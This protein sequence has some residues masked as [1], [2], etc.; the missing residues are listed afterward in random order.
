M[1][2]D[3][4][5][6]PRPKG[7]PGSSKD[8]STNLP[9]E[10][11]SEGARG[12]GKSADGGDATRAVIADRSAHEAATRAVPPRKPHIIRRKPPNPQARITTREVPARPPPEPTR[13]VPDPRAFDSAAGAPLVPRAAGAASVPLAATRAVSASHGTETDSDDGAD[14]DT[15]TANLT[16]VGPDTPTS[17]L[18]PTGGLIRNEIEAGAK[19]AHYELI[20]ELGRGGMAQVFLARDTKLGRLVAMKFIAAKSANLGKRFVAEARA[21]AACNHENIVTI[22]EVETFES[23]PYMVLEY[24]EGKP[25]SK[26]IRRRRVP[27]GRVVELIVP[28]VRAL[29]HAHELDLVHRDLKPDNVF[30]TRSGQVKVLDFGIAKA[31]SSPEA[32]PSGRASTVGVDDDA[33]SQQL[34]RYGTVVG[35]PSYM[36]PEQLNGEEIDHRTDLWAVGIIMFRMLAARHPLDS[37]KLPALQDS[38]EALDVP[39]PSI[40]EFVPAIP[41]AL[42]D[43]VDRCLAKHRDNRWTSAAEL[44][45]A[46]EAL[47]PGRM[48][49]A[50]K[51]GESPYPGLTAFQESDADR[52]FGR[53]GDVAKAIARLREN[54]LLGVVGPSGVGKSSFVRAGVVPTLK[55]SGETWEVFTIRPGRDPLGVL[56]SLI[57]DATGLGVPADVVDRLVGEPGLLGATLRQRARR[58]RTRILLFVD[59]FEELYT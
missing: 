56:S 59:Q 47:M 36:S 48:G 44:F 50:L 6:G 30:V 57:A 24:L 37:V 17:N 39:M 28:V 55:A 34:T 40:R 42:A 20:R 32:V 38:A 33:G 27:A 3:T 53:G 52:F 45:E 11:A 43:I 25:L 10:V 51:T 12:R 26:L 7:K 18:T 1:N 4:P 16:P 13:A 21:T 19:I 5:R 2:D 49:R 8:R 46:L 23:T 54:P 58:K 41:E 31:M 15:P 22:H 9:R 29:V 14:F 35:T